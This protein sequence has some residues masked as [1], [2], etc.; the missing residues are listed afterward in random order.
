MTHAHNHQVGVEPHLCAEDVRKMHFT[1]NDVDALPQLGREGLVVVGHLGGGLGDARVGQG[2]V[3]QR[4]RGQVLTEHLHGIEVASCRV[5]ALH[6][7]A[8]GGGQGVRIVDVNLLPEK[9]RDV[10]VAGVRAVAYGRTSVRE[11][12]S[13]RA[14]AAGPAGVVKGSGLVPLCDPVHAVVVIL[15][16]RQLR[17]CVVVRTY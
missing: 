9:R 15:P 14:G 12:K 7:Q 3:G 5:H 11:T 10:L 6:Q 17:D 1:R 13:K 8:E 2:A 4:G 16:V